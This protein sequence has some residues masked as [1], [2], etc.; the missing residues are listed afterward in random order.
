MQHYHFHPT[1]KITIYL[2][3]II[4]TLQNTNAEALPKNPQ[5]KLKIIYIYV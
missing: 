3:K 1:P 2:L 5:S 4:L